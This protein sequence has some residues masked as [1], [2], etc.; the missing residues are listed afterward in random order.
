MTTSSDA[1]D[2]C[3]TCGDDLVPAQSVI[4]NVTV[5]PSA[6]PFYCTSGLCTTVV[7][8]PLRT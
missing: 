3:P 2:R 5:P 4:D 7:Y 8:R 1:P 6:W